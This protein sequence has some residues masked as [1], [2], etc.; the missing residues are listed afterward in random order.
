M[1]SP[2]SKTLTLDLTESSHKN[3]SFLGGPWTQDAA[4]V[5]NA[6]RDVT[7]EDIALYTADAFAD[8]EAEFDFRWDCVWTTAA[9]V[10]R[11]A[12]ARHYYVID[13]PVVGQ[14]YRAEHFWMTIARVDERGMREGLAMQLVPGV[15]SAPEVWH[16]AKVRA[17]GD[18]ISVWLNGRHI[19]T[20][21][22]TTY[23][24]PG[25]VG[26][27]TYN[28]IGGGDE[29][30]SF[31]N[32][33]ITGAPGAAPPFAAEPGP[34]RN[35]R[36][37]DPQM[38]GGCGRIVRLGGGDLITTS[39]DNRL[40][41]SADNGRTWNI[42]Q[43]PES[44]KPCLM[45]AGPNGSLESYRPT[46]PGLP[47]Q[48]LK[49]VSTDKGKTWS[50]E[51]TVAQIEPPG[52]YTYENFGPNCMLETRDGGLLL[53]GVSSGGAEDL[54]KGGRWNIRF[55]ALGSFCLRSDDG[56]ETWS[57]P[58]NLDGPPYNDQ[59][60]VILKC[61]C[62]ISVTELLDGTLLS[63]S[64]PISSPFM[65]ETR[66]TDGGR[67]WTPMSR[68]SFPMYASC[69]SMITTSSGAVLMGGRFPAL[70]VQLSRDNGRSWQFYQLDTVGWANGAMIE[71][72][73]DVVLYV[74][75]GR[76]ELRH[77]LLR[78]TPAGLEP[79]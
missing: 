25:Y 34:S 75:G 71:V 12:D 58:V 38:A 6:T 32:F 53:C 10:F 60:F 68:G 36:L 18:L 66:S 46:Y 78:I 39:A 62:E 21:R 72:E 4:G 22:D 67:S 5:I 70:A 76:S 8:F 30:A 49:T 1:S 50:P 73:P 26:L 44:F 15:S 64:R 51:R 11:A 69:N 41:R 55:D 59:Y 54:R 37:T 52:E 79:V 47:A 20:I 56:G 74:Y 43:L 17:A 33:R 16:S 45:R 63:L 40:C 29:K 31:R 3:W 13:F 27:C 42:D 2:S 28:C 14:Q 48:L 9:F 23:T 61:G 19:T 24:A 35:W 65:W 7:D 57:G 77:Q